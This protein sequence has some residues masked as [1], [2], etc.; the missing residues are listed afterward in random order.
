MLLRSSV[1][2]IVEKRWHYR[3]AVS[4]SSSRSSVIVS[5]LGNSDH[6]RYAADPRRSHSFG[7]S[8]PDEVD[9]SRSTSRRFWTRFT[10]RRFQAFS[11]DTTL[12]NL[13]FFVCLLF[14]VVVK[15][16]H[17]RRRQAAHHGAKPGHFETSKIHFPTSEGVSERASE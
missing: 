7:R 9:N 15:Q 1:A 4:S 14:I 12:M 10:R 13:L 5:A 3:E 8:T 11:T 16:H 2:I 6:Q 17:R